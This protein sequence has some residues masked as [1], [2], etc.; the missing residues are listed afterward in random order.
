[1]SL[2]L[3]A[4]VSR[5]RQA[6]GQRAFVSGIGRHRPS[7]EEDDQGDGQADYQNKGKRYR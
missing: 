1:L 3:G 5:A 7:A 6:E 2:T 4:N